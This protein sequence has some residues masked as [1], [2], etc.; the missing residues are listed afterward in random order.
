MNIE[1]TTLFVAEKTGCNNVHSLFYEM[2]LC[3]C[4]SVHMLDYV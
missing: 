4:V 1:K 2:F 3:V